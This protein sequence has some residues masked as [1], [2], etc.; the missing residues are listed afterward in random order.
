MV[1]GHS[2]GLLSRLD[3]HDNANRHVQGVPLR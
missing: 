1:A 2:N 3:A